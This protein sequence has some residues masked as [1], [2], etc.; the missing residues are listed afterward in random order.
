MKN[1]R[2]SLRGAL[3]AGPAVL[4]LACGDAINDPRLQ[5]FMGCPVSEIVVDESRG[6]TLSSG[7]C[8]LEGAYTDMYY[9]EVF[10]DSNLII[11]LE[12]FDFDA[13]LVLY[14]RDTG[15][16]LADNDDLN[17]FDSDAR[18]AGYLPRGRYV[19]GAT[20]F[21]VGETG[22]YVLTVD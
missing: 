17:S 10:N 12:S 13:Y 15:E 14:D 16:L 19:I 6:G 3:L 2:R 20:S 22:Q 21:D 5:T 8:L 11:D 4:L 7:D 1:I 9:L 18:L